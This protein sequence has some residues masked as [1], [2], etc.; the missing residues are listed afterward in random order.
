MGADAKLHSSA[1]V[2][3]GGQWPNNSILAL[4]LGTW[5]NLTTIC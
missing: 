4:P 1:D 2:T 5:L 3:Y